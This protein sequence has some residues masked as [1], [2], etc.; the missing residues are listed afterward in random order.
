VWDRWRWLRTARNGERLLGVDCGSGAFA[1]GVAQLGY[2][3]L[4]LS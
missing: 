1:I 3:S 2:K 4:G